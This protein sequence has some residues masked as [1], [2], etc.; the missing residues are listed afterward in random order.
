MKECLTFKISNWDKKFLNLCE[1]IESWSKD[2][3]PVSAIIVDDDNTIVSTGYNGF[4]RGIDDNQPWM[5]ERPEKYI[6]TAH[7][8]QNSIFNAARS[9]RATKNCTLYLKWFPCHECARA[10]IQSGITR[11]VC[12]KPDFEKEKWGESFKN[13]HMM[14]SMANV[15][16]D[17]YNE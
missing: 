4:P 5:H 14:L 10:I 8:E 1:T 7:A 16:L 17:Y 6:F 15:K 13:S 9:G 3:T 12:S 2:S 11:V